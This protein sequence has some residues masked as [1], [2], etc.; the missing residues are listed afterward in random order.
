MTTAVPTR[1]VRR[2]RR[3][4]PDA[5]FVRTGTDG[6]DGGTY[7]FDASGDLYLCGADKVGATICWSSCCTILILAGRLLSSS[8]SICVISLTSRSGS[9]GTSDCNGGKRNGDCEGS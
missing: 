7:C 8:S 3:D 2:E 6:I 4:F 1:M 5:G 9:V